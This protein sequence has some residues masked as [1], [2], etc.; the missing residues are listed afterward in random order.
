MRLAALFLLLSGWGIVLAAL[1]LLG[2][3]PARAAF[4]WAGIAVE[5]LGLVLLFRSHLIPHG[6]EA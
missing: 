3:S 6:D 4:V 1:A 5:A 2:A